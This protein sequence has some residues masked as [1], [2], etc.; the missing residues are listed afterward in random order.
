MIYKRYLFNLRKEKH[1][2]DFL[3]KYKN[4]HPKL[5]LYFICNFALVIYSASNNSESGLMIKLYYSYYYKPIIYIYTIIIIEPCLQNRFCWARGNDKETDRLLEKILIPTNCTR[6][7][8]LK[9]GV[10][11]DGSS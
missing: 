1:R 11:A 6:E 10:P 8:T 9:Y 5:L 3:N 2:L 4:Y 7:F